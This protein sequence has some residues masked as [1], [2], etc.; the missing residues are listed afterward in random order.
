MA[1]AEIRSWKWEMLQ[2]LERKRIQ[3]IRFRPVLKLVFEM[4][5]GT[6]LAV[7]RR[8]GADYEDTLRRCLYLQSIGLMDLD[9]VFATDPFT[10]SFVLSKKGLSVERIL[11]DVKFL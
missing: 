4:R 3:D 1:D 11:H 8:S 2:G 10:T 6:I 9:P 7:A 5:S